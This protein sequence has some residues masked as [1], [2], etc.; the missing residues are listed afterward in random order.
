MHDKLVGGALAL[1]IGVG[2]AG[3]VQA[4]QAEQQEVRQVEPFPVAVEVVQVVKQFDNPEGAIFSQ[5][6]AHVFISNAAEIGDRG[7]TFG[8]TE[9][10]GYISKL[11][12]Q[13]D[14]TL[15]MVEEKLIAGLTGPLGMAVLPVATETFPEGTIFALS[16]SAPMVDPEGQVIT[17]PERLR[18]KISGFDPESGEVL[19]EIDTGQGSLFEEIN[20]SPIVL[21]NA[22]GFDQD[23][24]LYVAD[25]GFGADQ[26]D[27]PFEAKGGLWMIPHGSIDALAA[28]ESPDDGP[29]FIA[30]PGN[31]DGVEV[32]PLDGKIYVNTVGP[33][34]GAPDPANG[35]IYALTRDDFTGEA[36]SEGKLPPPV[37]Q[38]LGALDGLDFTA[39]GLMLNTQIKPDV[40]VAIYVNCPDQPAQKLEIGN[41]EQAELSGPA[42][43]AVLR[44]ES[45]GEQLVIVP[46]LMNRSANTGDNEVTVLRLLVDFDQAC[47]V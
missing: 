5:D 36:T 25:T 16:G 34:A 21:S 29:K 4:Q 22:A 26:F 3:A 10:E 44:S 45:G 38:D 37:D 12:V 17:E 30:I 20:G 9:E 18:T 42:D 47:I 28:G 2:A 27:P 43:L 6:G 39:G 40:D 14:G 33:V 32:S 13:E 23:G 31:P 8:W 46:E 19:G 1:S 11:A 7:E 15:E 35:G 24:N 41:S